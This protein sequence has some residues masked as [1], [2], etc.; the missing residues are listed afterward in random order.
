[1]KVFIRRS[2]TTKPRRG[3]ATDLALEPI[4]IDR[5]LHALSAV[6]PLA[7]AACDVAVGDR[8]STVAEFMPR[9][10]GSCSIHSQT[11]SSEPT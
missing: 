7:G 5:Q 3:P 2:R 10:S 8:D 11:S 9:S 4:T 1:M 6:L